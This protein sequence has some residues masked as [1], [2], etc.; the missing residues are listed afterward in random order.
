MKYLHLFLSL[1]LIALPLQAEPRF[2]EPTSDYQRGQNDRDIWDEL[3]SYGLTA[4]TTA[5]KLTSQG[6]GNRPIGEAVASVTSPLFLQV[7]ES[8]STTTFGTTSATFQN[9]NLSGV[10]KPSSTDSKILVLACGGFRNGAGTTSN[11]H[12]SLSRGSTEIGDAD[13]YGVIAGAAV[14]DTN[15]CLVKLDEPATTSATTYR[16][17]I[18]SAPA[19]VTMTF[20]VVGVQVM[21]LAEVAG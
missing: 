4:G 12:A 9:T 16:V 5:Y 20:G 15:I 13:G 19:G 7:L 10:I 11:G 2:P 8:S 17:R 6:S 14:T 1:F 21:I 3:Q 18:R